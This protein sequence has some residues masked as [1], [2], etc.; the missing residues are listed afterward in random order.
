MGLK[1]KCGPPRKA[2]STTLC[3]PGNV[4]MPLSRLPAFVTS[5]RELIDNGRPS[6]NALKVGKMGEQDFNVQLYGV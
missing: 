3:L 2:F 5:N 6:K 1:W 4:K